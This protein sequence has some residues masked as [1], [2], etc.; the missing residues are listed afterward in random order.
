[1][2]KFALATVAAALVAAPAAA[3]SFDGAYAG[4]SVNYDNFQ[5]SGSAEGAGFGGPGASG[6]VGYNVPLA[7]G[8]IGLEANIDVNSADVG[9]TQAEWAWGVGARAGFDLNAATS[10][11]GRVGYQRNRLDMPRNQW[12]DGVR[13]GVGVE[14]AV[15]QN[16]ALRVE[17]SHTDLE[18]SLTNNQ[19]AL[20]VV[21]GF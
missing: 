2:K 19:V 14:T 3:Q 13:L 5:G 16:T 20:G 1:M 18:R 15:A 17:F 11:Y 10:L 4:V 6:F 8:F 9:A 21:F 7:G 12:V